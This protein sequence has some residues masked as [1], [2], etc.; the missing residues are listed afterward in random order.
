MPSNGLIAFGP[1]YGEPCL[2]GAGAAC[3]GTAGELYALPVDCGISG[4][5]SCGDD[6]IGG[7]EYPPCTPELGPPHIGA[8]FILGADGMFG[9]CRFAN[10]TPG[11]CR[12]N[13]GGGLIMSPPCG[14]EPM[15]CWNLSSGLSPGMFTTVVWL[16]GFVFVFVLVFVLVV[17][18]D[19]V[20]GA[21]GW[22][23]IPI[24]VLI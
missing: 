19:P 3:P 4:A 8:L 17:P 15:S 1:P 14:S 7:G 24:S 5:P 16:T 18:P 12:F 2:C 13:G 21:A 6:C 23:T 9:P 10:G 11:F 20:G 22:D